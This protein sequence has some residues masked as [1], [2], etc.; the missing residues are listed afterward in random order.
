[1]RRSISIGIIFLMFFLTALSP[2]YSISAVVDELKGKVEVKVPGGTWK[3]ARSGMEI[4]L[5]TYISTGF[6]SK[7]ILSLGESIVEVDAL[8]RMELEE[9]VE[10]EG[11]IDT[12]LHLKVGK[13]KAEVKSS[14]GLRNNFELRSPVSTAAVRGTSF[15][16]DGHTI[17][18]DNGVVQFSNLLGQGIQV[19]GGEQSNTGGYTPPANPESAGSDSFEVPTT[20]STEG[21]NG[22]GSS[23]GGSDGGGGAITLDTDTTVTISVEWE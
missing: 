21:D 10:K 2:I 12:K 1:M 4:S 23:G 8:T 13:I 14:E 11:T 18:V 17:T 6:N 16:Y 5:G 9:L 19:G 22:G 7:A 20:P 15:E 3:K